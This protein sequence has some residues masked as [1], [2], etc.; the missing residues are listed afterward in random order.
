MSY[1]LIN[2]FI[3]IAKEI[4][5]SIVI[6][7]QNIHFM[8]RNSGGYLIYVIN[9]MMNIK[10]I[11]V[12]FPILVVLVK[13]SKGTYTS[14]KN[15]SLFIILDVLCKQRGLSEIGGNTSKLYVLFHSIH[16]IQRHVCL[17]SLG[18]SFWISLTTETNCAF[19]LGCK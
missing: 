3:F 5:F 17:G 14:K 11:F 15:N 4:C 13:T 1:R 18:K 6:Y 7:D 9:L 12:V 2:I 10:T 19:Y 16:I 8:G